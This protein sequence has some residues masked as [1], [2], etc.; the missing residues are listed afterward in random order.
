MVILQ[1]FVPFGLGGG[2]MCERICDWSH[3]V[4]SRE[5]AHPFWVFKLC[6]QMGTMAVH[7]NSAVVQPILMRPGAWNRAD[8]KEL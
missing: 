3:G 1:V 6:C 2:N 4:S 5:G 7:S 8:A